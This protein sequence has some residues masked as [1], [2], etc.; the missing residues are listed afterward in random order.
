MNGYEIEAKYGI[1]VTN[2]SMQIECS[3]I[4][5]CG[6]HASEHYYQGSA[7]QC[8]KCGSYAPNG[9]HNFTPRDFCHMNWEKW[10]DMSEEER[11]RFQE[12]KRA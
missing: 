4:C 12:R 3:E 6:H 10:C 2:H 8:K 11:Q 7:G 5:L 1:T 9:C